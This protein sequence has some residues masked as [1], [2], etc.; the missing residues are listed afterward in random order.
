MERFNRDTWA[1]DEGVFYDGSH[2]FMA[3]EYWDSDTDEDPDDPL[4]GKGYINGQYDPD[5]RYEHTV[6]ND[7]FYY[8][9]KT[10]PDLLE[11]EFTTDCWVLAHYAM[12][13]EDLE[14]LAEFLET[15][16]VDLWA[17]I[18]AIDERERQ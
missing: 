13:A 10:I 8:G 7:A 1:G 18:K 3:V 16:D 9:Y 17:E 11:G 2:V 4:Y 14:T 5:S 15:Y 12:D 6:Y